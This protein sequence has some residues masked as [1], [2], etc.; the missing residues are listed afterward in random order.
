MTHIESGIV[1]LRNDFK[2]HNL[3]SNQEGRTNI[4]WYKIGFLILGKLMRRIPKSD[5]SKKGEVLTQ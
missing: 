5:K 3:N 2:S 4:H 1:Y